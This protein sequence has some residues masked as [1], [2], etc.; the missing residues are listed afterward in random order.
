[1]ESFELLISKGKYKEA[2]KALDAEIPKKED[3]RMYYL[4][5]IVS[6][7]LGNYYYA[8]EMLEHALFL[9]RDPEYLK[10]KGMMLMETLDF[11]D[12]FEA[13]SEAISTRN[14]A[15][16]YFLSAICLMFL[17]SPKSR[18]YLQ[19][20]YLSD[21]KRAKELAK[22]FYERFFRKNRFVSEKDRKGLE[23]QIAAIK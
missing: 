12:A 9:K 22:E 16:A 13:F 10:F 6:G 3:P 7:K 15:E 17:N 19:L 11:S 2:A 4:R 18:E 8:H 20:A 14:D 21:R 5:A 23:A 1:M